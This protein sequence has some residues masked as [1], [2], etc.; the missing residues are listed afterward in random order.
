MAKITKSCKP[1]F[2][3]PLAKFRTVFERITKQKDL[4]QDLILK[5]IFELKTDINL[6]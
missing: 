6:N 3:L 5:F 1:Y 2:Y 4:L